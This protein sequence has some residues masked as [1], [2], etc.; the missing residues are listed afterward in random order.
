MGLFLRISVSDDETRAIK[1]GNA[2]AVLASRFEA[3]DWMPG[4]VHL[5]P[6]RSEVDV[7]TLYF[8][9]AT[10]QLQ[11]VQQTHLP[12]L[13]PFIEVRTV[14]INLDVSLQ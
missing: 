3:D 13:H 6:A 8:D 11:N 2:A 1:A 14:P 10:Q 4:A 12:L 9:P 7:M 5:S